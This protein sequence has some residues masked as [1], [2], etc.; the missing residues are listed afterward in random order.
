L[1]R[2]LTTK[3]SVAVLVLLSTSQARNVRLWG[4]S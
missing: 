4:P 2:E 1:R 3:L